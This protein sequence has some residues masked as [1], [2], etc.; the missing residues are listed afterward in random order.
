MH[1]ITINTDRRFIL[2]IIKDRTYQR[3]LIRFALPIALQQ[4]IM[5]SLNMVAV[6]MIGQL[7]EVAVASVGLANQIFFLLQLVLFGTYTGAAMFTAQFWGKGDIR[8]LRRVQSLALLIGLFVSFLFM[9]GALFTPNQLL[10]IYSRDPAVISLGSKFLRIFGL[11]FP[12]AAISFCFAIILRSTGE[13]KIPM[14]VS[15]GA[16]VF[17]TLVSY[18]LIFGKLGFSDM[19]VG[20]AAIS[21]L[22]ARSLEAGILLVIIY[23]KQLPSAP[24]IADFKSLNLR[25]V[26]NVFKPILPVILNET[27]WS[28][29]I[30]TY[31]I[32]YARISTEFDCSNEYCFFN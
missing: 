2:G 23:H 1:T 4:L 21:T 14:I 25:F 18:V 30:T 7:G 5:S 13:V 15:T 26:T 19:G 27:F 3:E 16:L 10:G 31:F 11:S 20:G 24:H 28:L 9:S 6:I 8:S 32:I 22:L 12:F 17:N 29:G